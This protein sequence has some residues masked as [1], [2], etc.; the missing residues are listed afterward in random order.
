MPLS[1]LHAKVSGDVQGVFFRAHTREKAE[2]LGVS[3][4]ARNT[5]DGG[6]EVVA[7]GERKL[8]EE[9]LAWLGK[10]PPSARVERVESAW[11]KPTGEFRGFGIKYG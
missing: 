1:R 6:V 11:E 3:G 4:W 2:S 9:F 5:G 10:G 7:E 8:L